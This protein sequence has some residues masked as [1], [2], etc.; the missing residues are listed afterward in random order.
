MKNIRKTVVALVA[1]GALALT[2]TIATFA[3]DV[4][5]PEETIIVE[6]PTTE[7]VT[8]PAPAEEIAP[9]VQTQAIS[10]RT[11]THDR[12][13]ICHSGS[14]KNWTYIAPD[15]N[16]Y[17]GHKNHE[18]DIYGLSEAECLAKNFQSYT[19]SALWLI[20]ASWPSDVTPYYDQLIFPQDRI[21]NVSE[22]PCERWAQSDTYLIENSSDEA[23]WNGLGDVLDQ[24]EDSAI[25]QSHEFIYGGDCETPVVN[26]VCETVSP[27]THSTDLA[28]L[29]SNVDTRSKGHVEYVEDGLHVWTDDNSSEAK[30]SEG[31]SVNFPLS[32]TGELAIDATAQAGNSYPNGPGLNLFVDITGDGVADG[33][34]VYETVYGQDLWVTNGSAQALKDAAVHTGGNGS[35]NHG[36]INQ[37]LLTFPD[38]TV[39]GLAYSL[40]SGVHGDWVINSITAN[41]LEHTFD[42]VPGLE[43]P[44]PWDDVVVTPGEYGG[45]QP[46]CE[47]P[48]V[49][50]TR[51]ISSVT[52]HY[53][54]TQDVVNGAYVVTEH[55][56]VDDPVI[57]TDPETQTVTYEGDDCEVVTPPTNTPEPEKQLAYTGTSS[58]LLWMV[59]LGLG[60]VLLGVVAW[61]VDRVVRARRNSQEQ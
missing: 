47:N 55:V 32:Q 52:T 33:T 51:E 36:T 17:N 22:I 16:G 11:Q 7:E 4:I 3:D 46:T 28:D 6:T 14:G 31:I 12:L 13:S 30:V 24:G 8:P 57:T 26:T 2:P 38:A 9:E 20:P 58:D 41:C 18:A 23:I 21:N 39:V 10:S 5:S 19:T 37:F 60:V 15:A 48:E 59:F 54:Y 29:W 50:W 35:E 25:Y 56:T 42:V 27:G 40:G 34:L 53:T 1:G 49:E 43:L 61:F 44:E 45:D